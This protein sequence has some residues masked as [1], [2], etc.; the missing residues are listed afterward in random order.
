MII[1]WTVSRKEFGAR[2][3]ELKAERFHWLKEI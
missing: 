1:P 2:S 3:F